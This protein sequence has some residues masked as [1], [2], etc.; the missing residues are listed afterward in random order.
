MSAFTLQY[1]TPGCLF[2]CTS[3]GSEAEEN[4]T[5][6][7]YLTPGKFAVDHL[8]GKILSKTPAEVWDEEEGRYRGGYTYSIQL[9]NETLGG[10]ALIEPCD[11]HD[12]GCPLDVNVDITT[13]PIVTA[14]RLEGEGDCFK[15]IQTV[16]KYVVFG[17]PH[18]DPAVETEVGS[19]CIEHPACCGPYP[20]YSGYCC[21]ANPYSN[22]A[23]W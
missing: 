10:P 9:D 14:V 11:V 7:L 1:T 2:S 18:P 3:R 12:T 13:I 23:T 16:K 5:V 22:P 17:E 4:E 19:H 8:D 6:R 20:Y 21:Q 15:V